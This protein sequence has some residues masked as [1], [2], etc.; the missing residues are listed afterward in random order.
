MTRAA[1]LA[2]LEEWATTNDDAAIALACLYVRAEDRAPDPSPGY[3]IACW[4][5]VHGALRAAIERNARDFDAAASPGVVYWCAATV[6]E[7][8]RLA[9]GVMRET[10]RAATRLG[11][12]ASWGAF[13]IG[14]RTARARATTHANRSPV[15]RLASR[16]TRTKRAQFPTP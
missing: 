12:T 14:E 16:A 9:R 1:L 15:V 6:A 2:A 10:R 11:Q 13:G 4:V 8:H 3:V 7:L 5:D